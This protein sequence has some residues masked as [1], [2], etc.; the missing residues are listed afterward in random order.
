MSTSIAKGNPLN[1]RYY[2]GMDGFTQNV[3]IIIFSI[4]AWAL[5]IGIF[6]LYMKWRDKK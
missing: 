2:T 4:I 1:G 3:L 6:K 5:T